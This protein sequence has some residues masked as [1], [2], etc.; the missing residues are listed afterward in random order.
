M[1]TETEFKQMKWAGLSFLGLGLMGTPMAQVL[2]AAG[3]PLQ[4][5]NRDSSKSQRLQQQG[6]RVLSDLT[7]LAGAPQIVISMLADGAAVLEVA[8]LALPNLAAGSIW[9]DMSSTSPA[10]AQLLQRL[11]QA[12]QVSFADAP[13]SG[14]VGAAQQAKLAIM[15]GAEA[16]VF[17]QIETILSVM[18]RVTRVG[19]VG[20]GQLA[21]LC[22]QLIVG[23][24]IS[25]VAE[26]LLL[27]QRGGADPAL[28]RQALRGGFAESR[29]LEVHGERM[30]R[31]E[32]PAGAKVT[33]QL[34]DMRN[35]LQQAQNLALHLP[36]SAEV[37]ALYQNLASYAPDLDH[38]AVLLEL[39]RLQEHKQ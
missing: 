38:A 16:G 27:A 12:S 3:L 25:I 39:E 5:W 13:V 9:I 33:T 35:I 21:K 30:L 34:K 36:V 17:A 23:G 15:V 4:V 11:C 37:L 2:H 1:T 22:N 32:F 29:V 8:Q 10:E 31:H 14:G 28:V 6:L 26:A 24:T 7:A 18:G 19:E 20:C